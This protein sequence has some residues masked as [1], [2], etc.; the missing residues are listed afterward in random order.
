MPTLGVLAPDEK[1]ATFDATVSQPTNPA[2]RRM[3]LQSARHA[4]TS[5]G[6][7]DHPAALDAVIEKEFALEL[8][9][10]SGAVNK[11][12]SMVS[13]VK[14]AQAHEALGN[15]AD[16]ARSAT[17]ALDFALDQTD[18][19][20]AFAIR[21]ALEVLARLGDMEAVARFGAMLPIDDTTRLL[22]GSTFAEA[23]DFA[24][25]HEFL[26]PVDE[27]TKAASLAYLVLNEGDA[28]KAVQLLRKALR[29]VPDDAESAHNLSVAFTRSG[30]HRKALA[31][32]LRATRVEPGRQDIS[33]NYLELLLQNGDAEQV[34]HEVDRLLQSGIQSTSALTIIQA[35][36]A[37]MMGDTKRSET[38]LA[39]A[40][41][42]LDP[43]AEA[44]KYAEVQSNLLR[45]RVITGHARRDTAIKQLVALSEQF[46]EYSV[47]V[48]NLAQLVDQRQHVP[49][50]SAAFERSEEY[51]PTGRR[52]FIMFQIAQLDGDNEQ[53]AEAAAEWVEA[54][55]DN[56]RAAFSAIV[57]LGIGMERWEEALPIA[58]RS[59]ASG[60][61]DL[62]LINN[63]A[64]V[65]AMSGRGEEAI[66]LLQP[67][68]QSDN[69]MKATLGLS[70]LSL[71]NLHEGLRLYREAASSA[72]AQDHVFLSLITLYQ[73]LVVKQLGLD[74]SADLT[75]V[76]AMSLA[77]IALPDDWRQRPEFLRLHSVAKRNGYPWPLHV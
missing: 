3:V 67:F 27:N 11:H 56:L 30:A 51:M 54:E 44:S 29:Q 38:Y 5:H 8:E 13:L 47:V 22:I 65:F 58:E 34:F 61:L 25:A 59:I 68:A 32:A 60:T 50:L 31:A 69:T 52:A 15:T 12:R 63:A 26:E 35:R 21:L 62:A 55:P 20:D 76:A 39:D 40:A 46:P 37:L 48:A 2:T 7:F 71:G 73:A 72:T 28:Q 42:Q 14:L 75:Q 74:R 53:A 9:R 49:L 19:G 10:A 57:A 1:T 17:A 24:L 66:R 16:A 41:R 18:E 36:A 43:K 6:S 45:I 70:F 23:G 33:L 4:S 77:P 64:Y